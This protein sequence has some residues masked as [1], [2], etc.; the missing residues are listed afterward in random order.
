M[1]IRNK[2]EKQKSPTIIE[3]IGKPKPCLDMVR[4]FSSHARIRLHT[5]GVEK[6]GTEEHSG[7]A[8]VRETRK[9]CEVGK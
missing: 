1:V 7:Y 3:T 5:A 9:T 8:E 6:Q 4:I 2:Q